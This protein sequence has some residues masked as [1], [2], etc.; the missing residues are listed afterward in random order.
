MNNQIL[1]YIIEESDA[2]KDETS[3]NLFLSSIANKLDIDYIFVRNSEKKVV[4]LKNKGFS[5]KIK[6]DDI[7]KFDRVATNSE[8][9]DIEMFIIDQNHQLGFISKNKKKKYYLKIISKLIRPFVCK[10]INQIKMEILDK[11]SH[12]LLTPMNAIIGLTQKLQQ[13]HPKSIDLKYI[14]INSEVLLNKINNIIEAKK[15]EKNENHNTIEEFNIDEL[16]YECFSFYEKK[17]NIKIKRKTDKV[18]IINDRTKIKD[19]LFKLIENSIKFNCNNLPTLEIMIN[20]IDKDMSIDLIDNGIGISKENQQQIFKSFSQSDNSPSREFGGLGLGLSIVKNHLDSIDGKISV[21]S[22]GE[23]TGSKFNIKFPLSRD[24][25][26][27][28]FNGEILLVE[29]NVINQD[30]AQKFLCSLGYKVVIANNGEEALSIFK[31][32]IYKFNAIIMDCQMPIMDGFECSKIIRKINTFIPIISFTANNY[33]ENRKRCLAAGMNYFMEKPINFFNFTKLIQENLTM[34]Y[35]NVFYSELASLKYNNDTSFIQNLIPKFL[36]NLID[37]DFP[38]IEDRMAVKDYG[39]IA[40]RCHKMKSS[41]ASFGSHKTQHLLS[42]YQ[43]KD[44]FFYEDYLLLRSHIK[45]DVCS[46]KKWSVDTD[47]FNWESLYNRF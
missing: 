45:S 36:R 43:N 41:F 44:E 40:Q 47:I 21:D 28:I 5:K 9:N 11:V 6:L 15:L 19:I 34:T 4:E 31:N 37:E 32:N 10:G 16:I 18:T 25:S 8:L 2:I 35:D 17:I 13:E 22:D 24:N 1:E 39:S 30:I 46:L 7:P 27:K 42:K 38:F 14:K 20:N 23:G 33:E 26:T 12:E 29:D 3:L